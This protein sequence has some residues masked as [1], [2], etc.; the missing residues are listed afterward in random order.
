ML[1][2]SVAAAMLQERNL[3]IIKQ[4]ARF[5]PTASPFQI[6]CAPT[7]K[8]DFAKSCRAVYYLSRQL[9]ILNEANMKCIRSRYLL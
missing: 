8:I 5:I 3:Y 4:Q 2:G 9:S 1:S 6:L 7:K